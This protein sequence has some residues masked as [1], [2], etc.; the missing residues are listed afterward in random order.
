M[1]GSASR[2]L[3]LASCILLLASCRFPGSVRPTVK[4]GLVAPFEGHYRYVGYDVIYAVRLAVREVNA[5]GGVGG[6]SIELV[7]YDDAADPAMALEQ[8]RKLAIDPQVVAVIGHFRPKTTAAAE[9]AYAEVGIPLVSLGLIALYADTSADELLRYLDE[10][11]L[12]SVALVT[13]GGPLGL[14]LQH[15][16]RIGSVVSLQD[17]DWLEHVLISDAAICDAEPVTAGEVVQALREAGW[18]GVFL[19]GPELAAAD[20]A[21]VAG[22]AAEG[23]RFV[24]PW[25]FPRDVPDSAN[26]V[27]AY[28]AMGPHVEPP[29]PLAL[30]AYEATWRVLEALE[31]DIVAHGTPT[32]EGMTA[33]LAEVESSGTPLYWYYVGEDGVPSYMP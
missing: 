17:A 3:L 21:A 28:Q 33:T 14:A 18:E 25:P 23:A 16:A 8:A 11:E 10:A 32:R 6:Y 1:Q 29:G 27:A 15:D 31:R 22:D 30:P 7:A 13:E 12:D 26:F 5:T 4:I 2:L 24:T 20:F 19:G 9:D